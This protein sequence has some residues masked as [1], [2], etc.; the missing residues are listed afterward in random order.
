MKMKK[1]QL[2]PLEKEDLAKSRSWV[3][4]AFLSS[5][6]LRVLPVTK[7]EQEEWY[8]NIVQNPSKIVFAIKTLDGGEHIGNTG[9]YR[10]DW[11]HRRAEFWILIGEQNFWRKGIGSEVVSLMKRYAFNNLNLNKLYLNVGADNQ[12][13]IYLY[14]KLIFVQEGISREHYYIEGKYLDIITMAILRKDFDCKE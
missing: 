7:D 12:E 11:I 14:K 6:M 4:D 5:R 8:Q 10:I 9:L 3:N 13:A 2:V 1:I